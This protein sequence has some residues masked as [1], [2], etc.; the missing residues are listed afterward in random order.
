[1]PTVV[2]T[3]GWNSSEDGLR[4]FSFRTPT[5][6]VTF[7]FSTLLDSNTEGYIPHRATCSWVACPCQDCEAAVEVA[8]GLA[9]QLLH[10]FQWT[11]RMAGTKPSCPLI[12]ISPA[13]QLSHYPLPNFSELPCILSNSY[14]LLCRMENFAGV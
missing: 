3:W 9:S 4:Y 5:G 10:E 7:R 14:H 1:M 12:Q 8:T 13:S 11:L 2:V 6:S